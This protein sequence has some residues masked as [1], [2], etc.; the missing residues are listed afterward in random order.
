MYVLRMRVD[1]GLIDVA[2]SSSGSF[3]SGRVGIPAGCFA[4]D[5]MRISLRRG[6]RQHGGA[7]I[8]HLSAGNNDL[9]VSSVTMNYLRSR[10]ETSLFPRYACDTC[11]FK[12]YTD[13]R[14]KRY[15]KRSSLRFGNENNSNLMSEKL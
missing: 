7:P 9:I 12:Y 2:A 15:T 4:A 3:G 13:V 5:A 8:T 14:L 1:D 11:R 10:M 6:E